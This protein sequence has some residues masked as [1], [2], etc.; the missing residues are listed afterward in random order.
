VTTAGFDAAAAVAAGRRERPCGSH[1]SLSIAA[2]AFVASRR[3]RSAFN[4]IAIGEPIPS[5]RVQTTSATVFR[6]SRRRIDSSH[7]E[8]ALLSGIAEYPK[9][10]AQN[11][12]KHFTIV[13]CFATYK[14]QGMG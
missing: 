10:H 2:D 12:A 4:G 1:D 3:L 14:E 5:S 13:K 11:V 6:A 9:G 7:P 8:S